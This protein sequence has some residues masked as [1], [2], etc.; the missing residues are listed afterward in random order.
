MRAVERPERSVRVQIVSERRVEEAQFHP[1]I[2]REAV[3][4]ARR[5][6]DPAIVFPDT[7]PCAA[8][9]LQ[10]FGAHFPEEH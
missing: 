2:I 3:R 7:G 9:V 5:M 4:Q 6:T 10:L 8:L 1:D